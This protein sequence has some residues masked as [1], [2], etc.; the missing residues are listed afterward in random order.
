MTNKK[1]EGWTDYWTV[2]SYDYK[3][4]VIDENCE[5]GGR[6]WIGKVVQ[7][8]LFKVYRNTGPDQHLSALDLPSISCY[9]INKQQACYVGFA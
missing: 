2:T 7:S 8:N 6:V 1:S 4:R 9:T 5:A 3:G